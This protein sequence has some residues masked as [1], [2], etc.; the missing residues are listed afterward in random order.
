M[1]E[2]DKNRDEILRL[3]IKYNGMLSGYIYSIVEDWTIVEEA[4]Q[5]TAVF[6]CNNWEKFTPGTNFGAWARTI[7]RM[8]CLEILHQEKRQKRIATSVSEH[9]DDDVWDDY[10]EYSAERKQALGECMNKLPR[11]L[12]DIIS[13]RYQRGLNCAAIADTLKKSLESIYMSL[14]RIRKSLKK[15]IEERIS[16]EPV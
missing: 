1:T 11:K 4:L 2:N 3:L 9:I 15:C 5:E 12:S 6:I 14:S 13:M 10:G 7:A 8:R 16:G